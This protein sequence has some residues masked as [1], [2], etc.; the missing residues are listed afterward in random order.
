MSN[1][2]REASFPPYINPVPGLPP[3]AKVSAVSIIDPDLSAPKR[4]VLS[5]LALH[6]SHA[7]K[8]WPTQER[9]AALAGWYCTD[10]KTGAVEPNARYVSTL[11]NNP[12][13]T[14]PSDRCGPGLVQYGYVKAGYRQRGL[15]QVID[16][17]LI[18]PTFDKG[19]ILRPD[20]TRVK[21]RFIEPAAKEDTKAYKDRKADEQT[22][23]ELQQIAPKRKFTAADQL[24]LDLCETYTWMGD[25]YTR[26][27]CEIDLVNWRDGLEREVPDAVYSYY[28]IAVPASLDSD[29]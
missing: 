17:Q 28:K 25:E 15:N 27:D 10:K 23:Y 8:A 4:L 9:I 3:L 16:Y 29:F 26:K 1:I 20:G 2:K 14:K 12:N 5:I 7:G 24:P 19:F 13:H 6:A 22:A 18:T 21:A 11:I